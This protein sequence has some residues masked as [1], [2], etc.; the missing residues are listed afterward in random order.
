MAEGNS[1][2]SGFVNFFSFG[3]Q[4]G[5]DI[6][7]PVRAAG[8]ALS[9]A[10]DNDPDTHVGDAIR[11]SF[12]SGDAAP[13]SSVTGQNFDL[14]NVGSL[15]GSGNE[16]YTPGSSVPQSSTPNLSALAGGGGGDSLGIDSSPTSDM[17]KYETKIDKLI[18]SVNAPEK[19]K[20]TDIAIAISPLLISLLNRKDEEKENEKNRENQRSLQEDK[21]SAELLAQQRAQEHANSLATM[22]ANF[23]LHN[24]VQS[25]KE[26]AGPGVS[27]GGS[28]N[29]IRDRK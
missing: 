17:S 23:Q 5:F 20:I 2:F 22:Q 24:A 13:P 21:I 7:S 26:I 14:S 6:W 1:W 10:F 25:V 4:G 8:G 27:I 29:V 19:T 15:V 28:R 9:A 12:T 16:T 18:E 3:D 11:N